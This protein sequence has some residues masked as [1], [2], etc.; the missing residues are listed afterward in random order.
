MFR[1]EFD[2]N[3]SA[4]EC[5]E[6]EIRRILDNIATKIDDGRKEGLVMDINGNQIGYWVYN[7]EER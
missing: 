4:F 7:E 5:G 3:N 2:T 1:I 6:N